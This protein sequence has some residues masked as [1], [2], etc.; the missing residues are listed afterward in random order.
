MSDED[1]STDKPHEATPRKLDEARKK[2]ELPKAADLTATAALLGFVALALLPGG[3]VPERVAV[4]GQALLDRADPVGAQMLG[5]GTAVMGVLMA[6]LARALAPAAILPAVLVLATLIALRGLVIA[7][8]KL[9]PKLSRISP[10]SNAKQKFGPSGL[11]E[12]AKSTVKLMVY[13]AILWLFLT[14]RL[15]RMLGLIAQSPGQVTA[16]MLRLTVEFLMLVALVMAVVSVGDYLFQKFDHLRRQ[17][18]S[19]RE[20]RDE[21]KSSEGDPYLK[22]TRRAKATA[23]ATNRMLGDVPTASVVVVN[24]THYAVALRWSPGSAGA[25]V[26][27]AKGVDE[28]ALRIRERAE[29]AGVP[30]RS[31]PP[32]AR[33]LYATVEI[34]HEVRPEQYAPVAVAIRFAEALRVKAAKRGAA[35]G[36]AGRPHPHAKAGKGP[37]AR[38]ADPRRPASDRPAPDNPPP[39]SGPGTR[40][41]AGSDAPRPGRTDADG[42]PKTR[43]TI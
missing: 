5:G 23:L 20:M 40:T 42:K 3:W 43:P 13:T 37:A 1:D 27:V 19:H 8:K 22:Q 2:G 14:S 29:A 4:L 26:C 35:I 21:I 31:D 34:G 12:F 24:P 25:P 16:E 15:P 38:S 9:E 11:F 18:M 36:G 7:P 6:D 10:L 41:Q 33:A 30:I 17:R 39:P 28:I 32:T